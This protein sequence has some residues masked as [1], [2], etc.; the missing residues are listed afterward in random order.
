MT[1]TDITHHTNRHQEISEQIHCV[2]DHLIVTTY[3]ISITTEDHVMPS[4]SCDAIL[5]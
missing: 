2:I 1:S 4:R 3:D 5:V